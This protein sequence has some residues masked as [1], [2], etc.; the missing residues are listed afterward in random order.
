[1]IY[2]ATFLIA[3][4]LPMALT[5]VVSNQYIWRLDRV[6]TKAMY[7]TLKPG[8]TVL[9][10]KNAY[11]SSAP[12]PGQ[13]VAVEAPGD[14]SGSR[15]LRILADSASAS[16]GPDVRVAGDSFYIGGQRLEQRPLDPGAASVSDGEPSKYELW[17]ERNR[18]HAYVVSLR[19]SLKGKPSYK[20]TTLDDRELY[21]LADNRSYPNADDRATDKVDSR[22]LGPIRRDRITGQPLYIAWST[23]PSTGEIRWDRIGLRLQ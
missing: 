7:P 9:V 15:I 21:L 12:T 8:D 2:I 17:V 22:Q 23:S 6:E 1:T 4:V 11:Q 3:Y 10:R 14:E 18:D 13:L 16:E 5:V 19:P 20:S